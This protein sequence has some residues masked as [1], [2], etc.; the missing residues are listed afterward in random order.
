MK[1]LQTNTHAHMRTYAQGSSPQTGS[2]KDLAFTVGCSLWDAAATKGPKARKVQ[3]PEGGPMYCTSP[4]P[5]GLNPHAWHTRDL[6]C[7]D[8]YSPICLTNQQLI[9]IS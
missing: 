5:Q 3:V 9:G 6:V 1:H 7:T 4:T 8:C 2:M